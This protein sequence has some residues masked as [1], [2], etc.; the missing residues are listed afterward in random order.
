ME[1]LLCKKIST[2]ATFSQS[3]K[4][5]TQTTLFSPAEKWFN[6]YFIWNG[7]LVILRTSDM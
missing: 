7:Y 1:I 5:L 3:L 4:E 6:N 2:Y